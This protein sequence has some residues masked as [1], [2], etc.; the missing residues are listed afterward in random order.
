M[1]RRTHV[2]A[3]TGAG[4]K[5]GQTMEE[6]TQGVQFSTLNLSDG[7][8]RALA[9]REIEMSTP[10]QAGAIPPMMEW[11]DITAKAPTGTGKTFAY[12]IPIV[13]HIDPDDESVCAFRPYSGVGKLAAG[14][15]Y[16]ALPIESNGVK[17][18]IGFE[19]DDPTG[20]TGITGNNDSKGFIYNVAGQRLE[21]MQKGVNI[22]NGKKILR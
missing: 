13:E 20:I 7:L 14:R 18:F 1:W 5:K 16:L 12:G 22:L 21:K 11:K 6:F 4:R 10:V 9:Q 15:A 8:M 3:R 2:S 19:E 17:Y